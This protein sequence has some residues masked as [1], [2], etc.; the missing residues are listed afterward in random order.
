MVNAILTQILIKTAFLTLMKRTAAANPLNP[1]DPDAQ[2]IA[3]SREDLDG[4][5]YISNAPIGDPLY[6]P[7]DANA[8]G[9]RPYGRCMRF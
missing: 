9:S 7:D 8:C 4:D 2:S 5:G 6:D 1:C 3:C